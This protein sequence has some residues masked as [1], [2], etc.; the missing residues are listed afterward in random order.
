MKIYKYSI[1]FFGCVLISR[2]AEGQTNKAYIDTVRNWTAVIDSLIKQEEYFRNDLIDG[3][4]SSDSLH[5][6]Y[7]TILNDL[8]QSIIHYGK[9]FCGI[10]YF[11]EAKRKKV[12]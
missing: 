6:K 9:G 7:D 3:L 5:L 2:I 11:Y 12:V 10:A 8:E 1:F 4:I